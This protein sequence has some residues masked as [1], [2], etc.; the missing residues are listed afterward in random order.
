MHG[1]SSSKSNV[2]CVHPMSTCN[3]TQMDIGG[4]ATQNSCG[5]VG[6]EGLNSVTTILAKRTGDTPHLGGDQIPNLTHTFGDSDTLD[7]V[8]EPL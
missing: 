6:C 2:S 5:D 7:Y 3:D 8:T 4:V 1:Q